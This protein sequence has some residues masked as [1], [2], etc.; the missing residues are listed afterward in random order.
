[1][2]GLA[3]T[4]LVFSSPTLLPRFGLTL[5]FVAVTIALVASVSF[6]VAS[7]R[8]PDA[9][10][11]FDRE[12]SR[13]AIALAAAAVAALLAYGAWRWVDAVLWNPMDPY[14]SDML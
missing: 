6:V 10:A 13:A 14:R 11:T 2:A 9:A 1:M 4:F 7:W 12:S 3:A 8:E 5:P